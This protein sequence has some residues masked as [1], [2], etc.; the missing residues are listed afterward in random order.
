M[1][2]FVADAEKQ[3]VRAALPNCK[4]DF[5][6][7]FSSNDDSEDDADGEEVSLLEMSE[8]RT[9]PGRHHGH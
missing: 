2:D 8:V 1:F 5:S 7:A 3:R 6:G 4:I 9:S